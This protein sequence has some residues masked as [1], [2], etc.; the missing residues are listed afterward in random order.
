MIQSCYFDVFVAETFHS[1][2]LSRSQLPME[3]DFELLDDRSVL[4]SAFV[5]SVFRLILFCA[6]GLLPF[7]ANRQVVGIFCYS[8]QVLELSVS[9]QPS[10]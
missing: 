7:S 4:L 9:H 3:E 1:L 8:A 2:A 10:S 5:R 6:G